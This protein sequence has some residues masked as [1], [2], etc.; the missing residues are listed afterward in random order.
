M[1]TSRLGYR[2]A[3]DGI[4]AL[5][6][7]GVMS[8][9]T[10]VRYFRWGY[11]GVDVFFVLSG[12]LITTILLEEYRATGRISLSRFYM[13]R[14]L[15]L[16]PAVFVLIA[17][18][19]LPFNPG[20]LE[21]RVKAAIIALAY[22]SNWASAF[23]WSTWMGVLQHLWSLA[24]EEQ[25][26]VF[27]PLALIGLLKSIGERPLTLAWIA[28]A[29]AVA[30][31]ALRIALFLAGRTPD[32]LYYAIDTRADG[33]MFGC[34]LGVL[35]VYEVY[36]A[37]RLRGPRL[38][39]P[40]AAVAVFAS[41]ILV[42]LWSDPYMLLAG[43]LLAA[44]LSG[45]LIVAAVSRHYPILLAALERPKLVWVGRISY[46]LYLWHYL[47][48]LNFGPVPMSIPVRTV[49]T[50]TVSFVMASASFYLVERPFLRLKDRWSA[51]RG[52][53]RR[54]LASPSPQVVQ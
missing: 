26:Y 42:S 1:T 50:F 9:H 45:G 14:A 11:L 25:F 2:P 21:T 4:R 15:R 44:L 6:V 31:A 22:C 20:P 40:A 39:M 10:G 17:V 5:A 19:L 7:L 43:Y 48:F 13:R 37:I 36:P 3:L 32:R 38:W 49:V 33:L 8:A 47:V 23:Q 12:F 27:W 51:D 28:A 52:N 34:M 53:T 35:F 30:S 18:S 24:C 54:V 16:F 46:S 29:G 41:P